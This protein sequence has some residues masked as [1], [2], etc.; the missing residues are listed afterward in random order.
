MHVSPDGC[1]VITASALTKR[2]IRWCI[3]STN[4][5]ACVGGIAGTSSGN[6]GG[7]DCKNTGSIS[8]DDSNAI[9]V[10]GNDIYTKSSYSP[11]ASVGGIVGKITAGIA[12]GTHSSGNIKNKAIIT[13]KF[14]FNIQLF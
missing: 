4:S 14:F 12:E 9:T 8:Y 3:S 13:N 1:S 5:S 7:G 6:V 2:D 11:T 10:F